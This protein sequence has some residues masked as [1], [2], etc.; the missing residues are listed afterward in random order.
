M[1]SLNPQA[2]IYD[3]GQ[4]FRAKNQMFFLCLQWNQDPHGK[5]WN[6]V[7]V[8]IP[9]SAQN[10]TR[11]SPLGGSPRLLLRRQ[12]I[13]ALREAPAGSN[14]Y[15]PDDKRP[16]WLFHV[17][18]KSKPPG[19]RCGRDC[20]IRAKLNIHRWKVEKEKA[21]F[22]STENEAAFFHRP[23]DDA[24]PGLKAFLSGKHVHLQSAD[25]HDKALDS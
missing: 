23:H 6:L 22:N 20:G 16:F 5:S 1:G 25:D 19:V 12:R 9:T 11:F 13:L 17:W 15:E 4:G 7:C 18:I 21:S 3:S 8:K 10:P 2:R 14:P 24:T